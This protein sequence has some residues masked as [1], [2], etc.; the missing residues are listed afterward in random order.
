[1]SEGV[2]PSHVRKAAKAEALRK[3]EADAL[4]DAGLPA[5]DSFEAVAREWLSL[6]HA[7]KVSDGQSERTE[8]APE[9]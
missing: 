7:A 3:R 2:D 4:A 5:V 8:V 6:V 1:M 9:I